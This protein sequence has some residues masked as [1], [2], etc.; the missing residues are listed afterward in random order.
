MDQS[1]LNPDGTYNS[2]DT[3]LYPNRGNSGGFD[4]NRNFP[5]P[6]VTY[7]VS[8]QKET[9]M[10]IVFLSKEHHFA[11]SASFHSGPR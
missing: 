2:G 5:D 4:L 11:L 10:T 7:Q 8:R 3:I 9:Q 1:A 6:D